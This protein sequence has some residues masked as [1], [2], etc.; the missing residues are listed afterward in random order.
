[1]KKMILALCLAS[2]SSTALAETISCTLKPFVTSSSGLNSPFASD[3]TLTAEVT[4]RAE[5]NK[6]NCA[7]SEGLGLRVS[8]CAQESGVMGSYDINVDTAP[9]NNLNK[10]ETL[11]FAT[12]ESSRKNSYLTF[13]RGQ[14]QVLSAVVAKLRNAR[15]EIPGEII[16]SSAQIEAGIAL[17]V[18]KGVLKAGELAIVNVQSCKLK[19]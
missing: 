19:R 2:V 10:L 5:P 9:A 17:G 8:L 11:S 16:D 15:I 1:M 7:V 4:T 18:N 14:S 6:S 13:V 12:L 3:V